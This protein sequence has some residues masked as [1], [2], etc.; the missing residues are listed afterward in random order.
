MTEDRMRAILEVMQ[1]ISFLEWS[2]LKDCVDSQFR[3]DASNMNNKIQIA[4]TDTII[5]AY[6]RNFELL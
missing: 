4:D 5:S 2:K 1:E 6:K 3:K